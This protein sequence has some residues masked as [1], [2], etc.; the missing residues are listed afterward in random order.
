MDS[1]LGAKL[2]GWQ[3]SK[4][5]CENKIGNDVF[6]DYDNPGYISMID[7]FT[8]SVRARK[9][10]TVLAVFASDISD[11]FQTHITVCNSF[12]KGTYCIF[13]HRTRKQRAHAAQAGVDPTLK[14][15]T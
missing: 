6:W 13:Q 10:G 4:L 5:V 11:L 7:Q 9:H 15:V 2:G 3:R 8:V 12:A 14:P 1:I